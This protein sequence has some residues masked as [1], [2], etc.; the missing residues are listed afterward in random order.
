MIELHIGEIAG[1]SKFLAGATLGEQHRKLV[2]EALFA[3]PVRAGLV[4]AVLDFDGIEFATA[5]YLKA[6]IF[7]LAKEPLKNSQ[8]SEISVFPLVRNLSGALAEELS[9]VCR[10]E[11]FTCLEITKYDKKGLLAGRVHGEID[12]SLKRALQ[13][14]RTLSPATAPAL[15]EQAPDEKVNVT[16]WNN[17]LAELFRLRLA[18]RFKDGR[19]WKYEPVI[20]Q[21]IYG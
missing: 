13:L 18:T 10:S 3:D 16:A 20:K 4:V 12:N 7:A 21:I 17:R 11:R 19:F 5:S 8:N 15:A 1:R 2:A 6:V 14:L 9:I